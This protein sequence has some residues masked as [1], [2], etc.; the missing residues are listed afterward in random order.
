MMGGRRG[1]QAKGERRLRLERPRTPTGSRPC[2][3]EDTGRGA[4]RGAVS[5]GTGPW[6][7]R[8]RDRSVAGHPASIAGP[9]RDQV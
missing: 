4:R 8:P 5:T 2:A 7:G 6:P 1:V 9:P 3:G